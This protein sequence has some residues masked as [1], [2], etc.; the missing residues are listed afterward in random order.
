MIEERLRQFG[1]MLPDLERIVASSEPRS[2]LIA[3]VPNTRRETSDISMSSAS[4]SDDPVDGMGIMLST[5]ALDDD[6][7]VG[8]FGKILCH[9]QLTNVQCNM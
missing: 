6:T 1:T 9:P 5:E 4:P 3:D 8:Y 2:S 7:D